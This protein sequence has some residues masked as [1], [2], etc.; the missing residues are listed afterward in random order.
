MAKI[1]FDTSP[2]QYLYQ[3]GLIDLIPKLMKQIVVPQAVVDELAQG[4]RIGVAVPDPLKLEWVTV[5]R[6]DSA[7][8]LLLAWD[9]GP[10][11][12]EALALALQEAEGLVILDDGLARLAAKTLQ[13][14]HMG[15]LGILLRAKQAMLLPA[16]KPFLDRL[17]AGLV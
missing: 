16:V 13:I 11:E 3:L 12:R 9:L 15:T 14:P 2:L 1:I 6:V 17:Q 4:S 10:G 5:E 7:H 8:L